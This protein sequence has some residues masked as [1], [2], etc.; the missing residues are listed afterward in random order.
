MFVY[1]DLFYSS[2]CFFNL[3]LVGSSLYVYKLTR[4]PNKIRCPQNHVDGLI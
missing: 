1:Y 2:V 4:I 3:F